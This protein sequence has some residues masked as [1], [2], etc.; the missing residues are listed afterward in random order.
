MR[1]LSSLVATRP[2]GEQYFSII[3]HSKDQ[4]SAFIGM[5]AHL[6]V[7]MYIVFIVPEAK[8]GHEILWN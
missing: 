2:W 5:H 3:I 7:S 8:R 6:L 1:I 4:T